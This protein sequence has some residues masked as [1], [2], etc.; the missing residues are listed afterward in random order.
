MSISEK[1]HQYYTI[2][3][4]PTFGPPCLFAACICMETAFICESSLDYATACVWY[5]LSSLLYAF[6]FGLYYSTKG[7]LLLI[8]LFLTYS[9]F[10]MELFG[11]EVLKCTVLLECSLV[12][13]QCMN[14]DSRVILQKLVV[15]ELVRFLAVYVFCT[16][17]RRSC[18]V[19]LLWTSRCTLCS[20]MEFL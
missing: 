3:C 1:N 15:P 18:H 2:Y 20:H 8:Y 5:C 12:C 4:I 7:S 11:S 13:D 6:A 19:S 17:F 16:M 9:I 10:G 14:S